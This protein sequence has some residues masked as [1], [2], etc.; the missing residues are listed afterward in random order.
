ML[1]REL[2]LFGLAEKEAKVYIAILELGTGTVQEISQKSGINR[3]TTYI[4]IDS[5]MRRGL[6]SSVDKDK[7]SV[8]MAEKPQR[9]LEILQNEKEKIESLENKFTALMP[10]FEAI[11]NVLADRPR[12]RFFGGVAGLDIVRNEIIKA[13]PVELRV[14]L[15]ARPPKDA[16]QVEDPTFS[17]ISRLVGST[18]FLIMG[19]KNVS[20]G[21]MKWYPKTAARF[22]KVEKYNVEIM[23]FSNKVVVNKPIKFDVSMAVM[24]EDKL[25]FESFVAMFEGLWQIAQE[26]EK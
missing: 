24:I 8:F 7:K 26:L 14:F 6:I 21:V 18:K 17:K 15:P 19:E 22:F 20:A 4:Q 23:L 11:Y 12:V 9:L 3:A 25:I 13:K 2:Q 10:D 5:L 1:E 16:A